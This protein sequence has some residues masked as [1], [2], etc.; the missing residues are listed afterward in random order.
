MVL[1][2]NNQVLL[3]IAS[4]FLSTP[5]YVFCFTLQSQVHHVPG[6][7]GTGITSILPIPPR[8]S[9][10]NHIEFYFGTKRGKIKYASV[11]PDLTIESAIP[12]LYAADFS[13]QIFDVSDTHI[14]SDTKIV[15]KPYPVYSMTIVPK[16]LTSANMD[17]DLL[18]GSGD[19]YITVW[20]AMKNSPNDTMKLN[21]KQQLGPHTG[22]VKD[23]VSSTINN[24]NHVIFSIGCNCI[25]VWLYTQN[26]YKHSCKLKIESS[27]KMGST[28]SSDLLCLAVCSCNDNAIKSDT[29]DTYLFAGGVDGRLHRWLLP[30]SANAFSKNSQFI[31]AGVAAVHE[32]RLNNL[33]VCNEFCAIVSIGYDGRLVCRVM[34][35]SPF[36]DWKT[37]SINMND[38][39]QS[40][41]AIKLS[42]SCIVCENAYRALITVGS[43]CGKVFLVQLSRI[44]S[45][46]V[47]LLLLDTVDVNQSKDELYGVHTLCS[48]PLE[49]KTN[50]IAIGHS[51]GISLLM[52]RF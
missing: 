12:D 42:A 29:S 14:S 20:E 21:I 50:L 32:G 11:L 37:S 19:R 31:N 35:D 30:K 3:Y 43:S 6:L 13:V 45:D 5:V 44:G 49:T 41:T 16:L 39:L 48:F 15:L 23:V 38:Q 26:F 18:S 8:K 34:T 1:H 10:S 24:D 52:I 40:V 7:D 27:V 47:E 36:E 9:D 25:E 17:H 46:S 2:Q 4:I 51:N 22:W 33:L 28:L